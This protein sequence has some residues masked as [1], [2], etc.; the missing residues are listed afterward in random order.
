MKNILNEKTIMTTI[1]IHH[2]KLKNNNSNWKS[3]KP[4]RAIDITL[5]FTNHSLILVTGIAVFSR[6]FL[7]LVESSTNFVTWR[8]TKDTGMCHSIKKKAKNKLL[9]LKP[10]GKNTTVS[11][12]QF[13]NLCHENCRKSKRSSLLLNPKNLH[14]AVLLRTIK[15]YQN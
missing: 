7:L 2:S 15:Y 6:G 1:F 14:S 3:N 10:N 12:P 4:S 5:F 8:M 9:K 11:C 13:I